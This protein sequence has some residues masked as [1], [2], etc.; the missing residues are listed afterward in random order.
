M[1]WFAVS[2]KLVFIILALYLLRKPWY[3][4]RMVRK[5][6]TWPKVLGR[7]VSSEVIDTSDA[8]GSSYEI[9]LAYEYSVQGPIY[10][11][12]RFGWMGNKTAGLKSDANRILESYPVGRAVGVYYD[13]SDPAQAVLEPR[14]LKGAL[15]ATA[16]PLMILAVVV[17]STW[18]RL[19]GQ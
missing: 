2:V 17:L 4:L 5:S 15:T 6:A 18:V 14:R 9:K 11:C 19:A 12:D 10:R 1:G 7:I 13:P 3:A 16:F 8:E